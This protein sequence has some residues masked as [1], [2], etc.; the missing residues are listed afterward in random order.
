MKNY[1]IWIQYIIFCAKS[2]KNI[3][4]YV[5]KNQIYLIQVFSLSFFRWNRNHCRAFRR[6]INN[7]RTPSCLPYIVPPWNNPN[8]S[9]HQ[10]LDTAS[11]YPSLPLPLV[12]PLVSPI[13][14]PPSID[15]FYR[16]SLQN[17]TFPLNSSPSGSG[18]II[19]L[20]DSSNSNTAQSCMYNVNQE[21][22]NRPNMFQH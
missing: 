18:D 22:F 16:T 6:K 3:Q 1:N 7:I 19:D 8:D 9:E 5:N 21:Y 13:S 4:F 15:H 20:T 17:G 2:T 14:T 12:R 11:F 10:L